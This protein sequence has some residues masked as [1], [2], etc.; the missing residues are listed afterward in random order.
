M[1]PQSESLWHFQKLV[2]NNFIRISVQAMH[3][4]LESY[5]SLILTHQIVFN[6][7]FLET[8]DHFYYYR[9]QY[10]VFTGNYDYFI[11]E[12][13]TSIKQFQIMGHVSFVLWI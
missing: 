6:L 7:M 9:K 1:K 12:V 8:S 2:W 10:R 11:L 5:V 3:K 13:C 4:P